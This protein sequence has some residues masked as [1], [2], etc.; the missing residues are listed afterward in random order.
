MGRAGDTAQ[1]TPGRGHWAEDTIWGR[2]TG[3]TRQGNLG[4]LSQP[5]RCHPRG[6]SV[7]AQGRATVLLVPARAGG[8]QRCRGTARAPCA[9]LNAAS[10]APGLGTK[11]IC[12]ILNEA[13][14]Y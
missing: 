1:G 8:Q 5:L 9:V 6:R 13:K 7:S 10:F 14:G 3:E 12:L 2:C 4:S 11:L